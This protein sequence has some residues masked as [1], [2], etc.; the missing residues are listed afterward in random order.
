MS[1]EQKE[2]ST[3]RE[4]KK[5]G[6]RNRI[7]AREREKE[8]EEEKGE[9]WRK[10]GERKTHTHGKGEEREREKY[11]CTL[12]LKSVGAIENCSFS[13][14]RTAAGKSFADLE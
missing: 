2:I 9:K 8:E 12:A 14:I 4:K 11:R 7:C 6:E 3:Q 10:K 1:N 13:E 5:Y